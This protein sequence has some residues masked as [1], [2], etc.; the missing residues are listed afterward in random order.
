MTIEGRH[1]HRHADEEGVQ[2]EVVEDES[3]EKA[4]TEKL[5]AGTELRRCVRTSTRR[6][7]GRRRRCED[8]AGK[9]PEKMMRAEAS[10]ACRVPATDETAPLQ[11]GTIPV[12]S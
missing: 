1:R 2:K 7:G 4:E 9:V 12:S 8:A 3:Q 11:D 10:P 5:G 6:G